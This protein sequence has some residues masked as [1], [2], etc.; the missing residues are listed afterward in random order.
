MI[1]RGKVWK[2]GDNMQAGG[3]ITPTEYEHLGASFKFVEL[4]AH[5]FEHV[6]P[7][8]AP[9]VQKGD[10]V[11][12]GKNFGAGHGHFL[13]PAVKALSA[14]GVGACIAESYS[15]VFQRMAINAGFPAIE[16][17]DIQVAVETGDEL[18]V[19]LLTGE[20]KNPARGGSFQVRPFPEM[21]VDI[22]KSGGF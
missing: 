14:T 11:V 12:A 8:F 15:G 18:E 20:G 6:L 4:A 16:S 17:R 21:I 2:V 19:N 9:A 10:F 3:D 5:V 22:L 7:G 1:L 13:V